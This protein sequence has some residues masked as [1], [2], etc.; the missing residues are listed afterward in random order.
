MAT[1][2]AVIPTVLRPELAQAIRSVRAQSTACEVVLGVDADERSLGEEARRVAAKADTVV[3]TGGGRGGSFARNLATV[4]ASGELVAYL[5]DDDQWLPDRLTRQLAQTASLTAS[6]V[7]VAGRVKQ[8]RHGQVATSKPVPAT[9]IT[10]GEHVEDYLFR[11]RR[12]SVG[13][14]GIQTST[15]LLTRSLAAQVGWDTT[16]RRHQDWDFMIRAQRSGARI[17]MVDEAVA[18]VAVGSPG[19]ISASLDW[20]ASLAWA[21]RWVEDWHRATWVDF[22]AGQPLRYAIGQRSA[23]GVRASIGR[24]VRARN[25]P[26]WGP[27]LI[28]L[29]GLVPRG[30]LERLMILRSG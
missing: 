17:V 28:A 4:A 12:P 11:R 19:S 30:S 2:S 7:I 21:D 3:F 25:V 18:I 20:R 8:R 16:L 13:R 23:E 1:V 14:S 10:G 24:I 5:D 29:T 22:V 9:P 26:S 15:L 27:A 6:N